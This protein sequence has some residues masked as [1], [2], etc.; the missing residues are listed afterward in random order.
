MIKI[1]VTH[2]LKLPRETSIHFLSIIEDLDIENQ[3]V[4]QPSFL[5]LKN[6]FVPTLMIGAGRYEEANARALAVVEEWEHV[7][8]PISKE[9]LHATYSNLAYIDMY[10][11]T[12]S[13]KYLSHN[14]MQTAM[15]YFNPSS[16]PFSGATSAFITPDM[17]SFACL[18]GAGATSDEMDSFLNDTRQTA[19]QINR[20]AFG[21]YAGYDDLLACEYAYYKNQPDISRKHAHGAIMRAR[22][23]K[24]YT[25][26]SMAE[27]YLLRIALLDGDTALV[28]KILN[29]MRSHLDNSDFKYR[30][31]Y[32]DLYT[33]VFYALIGLPHLIPYWL[34]M[35]EKENVSEI[36]IPVRELI[37]SALYY[38]STKKYEHALTVLSS[39]YPRKPHERFLFGE[40]KLTLLTAIARLRTGDA[41]GAVADFKKAYDMS[42]QGEYEMFFIERG[43]ELHPLVQAALKQGDSGMP[44]AWLKSIDRRA[45]IFAKKATVIANALK[46]RT[47]ARE[48]TALSNRESDVLM[49]LFHGLSREEIAAN[50]YLSINTVKKI[51]QSIYVKLDAQNSVDAVRIALEKKLIE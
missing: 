4:I 30:N 10:I 48:T 46:H 50:Q 20:T 14:Y 32:F 5:F 6:V 12:S 24:Q 31:L 45:S 2:S 19:V 17:R 39:S 35:D 15:R 25:V 47:D 49:D 42:F 33:G 36:H 27:S 44:H 43:R 21:A 37:I 41:H 26:E 40:I 3:E 13:H 38:I 28:K 18:V 51:L 9:L 11:C 34:I 22:E 8:T 16:T 29:Q 7:D 23:K 1:L